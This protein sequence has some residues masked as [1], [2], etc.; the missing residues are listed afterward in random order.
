L[1]DLT[2]KRRYSNHD[3][4][5]R[6]L[7]SLEAL[8]RAG[9]SKSAAWVFLAIA[10]RI[11]RTTGTAFP[12]YPTI[13]ADAGVSLRSA[14]QSVKA[15]VAAGFLGKTE[16]VVAK[17]RTSNVYT[18][19]NPAPSD[20]LCTTPRASSARPPR[21]S[22]APE[23]VNFSL[24]SKSEEVPSTGEPEAGSQKQQQEKVP[25]KHQDE[26]ITKTE[27]TEKTELEKLSPGLTNVSEE[28]A[29]KRSPLA[30]AF[31]DKL[32]FQVEPSIQIH[33]RSKKA[34]A[35]GLPTSTLTDKE[36]GQLTLF[37]QKVAEIDPKLNAN[38]LVDW[39]FDIGSWWTISHLGGETGPSDPNPGFVLTHVNEVVSEYLASQAKQAAK[40]AQAAAW[41][42]KPVYDTAPDPDDAPLSEEE[43]YAIEE[44][45]ATAPKIH[46]STLPYSGLPS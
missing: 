34:K 23:V 16:R 28:K 42:A 12:S 20:K 35:L 14:K 30:A 40:A 11:N 13:A 10:R 32:R 3:A 17:N 8:K 26:K 15:L 25:E 45:Y 5:D 2:S 22:S 29:V 36:A 1:N 37:A 46:S 9:L 4:L 6:A 33:W 27:N 41:E 18:L 19:L 7:D 31:A 44:M 39:L 43:M 24:S 21:A 38:Q